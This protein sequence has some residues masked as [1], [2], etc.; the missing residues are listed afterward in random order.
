[1]KK[2]L[3]T[4][5][6]LVITISLLSF[7][8]PPVKKAWEIPAKYKA[9]QNK[10]KG[11][12]ASIS[13][14]KMLYAKNCKSCHGLGKGDGPKA[15]T[16]KTKMDDLTT[17]EFKAIPDGDKYFMVVIGRDEMTSFD[18]KIVEEDE[19]WAIVNYLNTL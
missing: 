10:K 7:V 14:G 6:S 17:N 19:R 16:L 5:F 11:D 2:L 18:K 1:M 12:P 13:L 3:F 8:A 9:M 4:L 15:A